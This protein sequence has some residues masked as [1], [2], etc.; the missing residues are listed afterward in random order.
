MKNKHEKIITALLECRTLAEVSEQCKIPPR[1]LY[2]LLQDSEFKEKLNTAKSQ[3]LTQSVLKLN[4]L[5]SLAIDTLAEIA[6]NAD[7]QSQARVTA[8]RAI[9]DQCKGFNEQ[10]DILTRLDELE[11][12]QA[13]NS[14]E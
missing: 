12:L 2:T 7:E 9:L 8:S 3:A 11:R 13:E 6:G 14:R 5:T 4:H 1:T 10:L